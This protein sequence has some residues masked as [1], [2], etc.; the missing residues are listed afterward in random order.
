MRWKVSVTSLCS[1]AV[2][3]HGD[4]SPCVAQRQRAMGGQLHHEPLR[5]RLDV[6]PRHP[7]PPDGRPPIVMTARWPTA[8]LRHRAMAPLLFRRGVTAIR[9]DEPPAL[10]LRTD[11]A[12][13]DRERAI[14]A[15]ADEHA[16]AAMSAGSMMAALR[17]R[18]SAPSRSRRVARPP[19]RAARRRL[20]IPPPASA[21][22]ALSASIVARS[23]SVRSTGVPVKSAQSAR[24]P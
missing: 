19:R 22:S 8:R 21:Y 18:R 5:Q 7:P 24:D 3:R 9:F 6:V 13:I 2:R 4:C 20:H 16:G 12:A 17:R 15:D 1:S 11:I 14:G 10:V 23:S